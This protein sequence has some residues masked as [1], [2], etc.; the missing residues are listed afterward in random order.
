MGRTATGFCMGV[1][2]VWCNRLGCGGDRH[3]SNRIVSV[4][5]AF[6]SK[7]VSIF[8]MT[9]NG[10]F[11]AITFTGPPHSVQV[12]ISMSPTAPTFCEDTLQAR[13]P[14]SGRPTLNRRWRL[15]GYPGTVALAPLCRCHLYTVFAVR[16]EHTVI[17]SLSC[18]LVILITAGR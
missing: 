10:I 2:Q 1:T 11:N 16:C 15:I 12:A 4:T 13:R 5:A 17:S 8:L 6:S 3:S 9:T 18:F 7:W 14:G